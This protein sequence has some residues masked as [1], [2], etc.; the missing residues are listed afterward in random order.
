[1]PMALAVGIAIE[2]GLVD[3]ALNLLIVHE[4]FGAIVHLVRQR[5]K[6]RRLTVDLERYRVFVS[7]AH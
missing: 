1:M 6:Q 7:I 5:R 4:R 2:R 3:E